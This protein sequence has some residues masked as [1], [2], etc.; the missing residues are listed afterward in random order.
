[1]EENKPNAADA[2]NA[3]AAAAAAKQSL[4]AQL[5]AIDSKL[6]RLWKTS[7]ATVL[8][9]VVLAWFATHML[10]VVLNKTVLIALGAVLGYHIDRAAFPYG[11]P[12]EAREL[13]TEIHQR[14]LDGS[15]NELHLE[16]AA[17]LRSMYD[18]STIRRAII[19]AAAILGV[20]LAA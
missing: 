3:T 13:L 8:A 1:M 5:K 9:L 10:G 6:P 2:V 7:L 11:R 18:S 12:H 19:I 15:L 16:Y 4:K 17:S 20:C 14:A